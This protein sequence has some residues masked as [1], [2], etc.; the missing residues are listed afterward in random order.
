MIA[1]R[2]KDINTDIRTATRVLKIRLKYLLL[3]F[4]MADTFITRMTKILTLRNG[5]IKPFS[6]MPVCT[7][8]LSR[9]YLNAALIWQFSRPLNAG[10]YTV[11]S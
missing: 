11:I 9:W 5:Q 10:R 1:V 4:F 6:R 3:I 2:T 7:V 8:Y